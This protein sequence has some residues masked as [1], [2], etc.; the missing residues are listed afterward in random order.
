MMGLYLAEWLGVMREGASQIQ[1][2]PCGLMPSCTAPHVAGQSCSFSPHAAGT[3]AEDEGEC[4]SPRC[5]RLDSC[6][7]G[8]GSCY[9]RLGCCYV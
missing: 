4:S 8:L 7:V 2:R 9:V 3:V 1:L 6:R 5:V